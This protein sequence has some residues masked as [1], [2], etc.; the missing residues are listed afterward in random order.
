[1]STRT[2]E[3]ALATP[4]LDAQG[5]PTRIPL[6]RGETDAERSTRISAPSTCWSTSGRSTRPR[7]A[8][9]GW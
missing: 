9:S 1:M 3:M 2:V 4:G 7:T 8:C 6:P 5:R